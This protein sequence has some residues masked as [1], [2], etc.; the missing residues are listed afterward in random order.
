MVKIWGLA[1]SWVPFQGLGMITS[2]PTTTRQE[3][4]QLF[5]REGERPRQGE[6]CLFPRIS[7]QEVSGVA[8]I[9]PLAA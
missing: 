3:Q 5:L 4:D 9:C 1:G 7:D 8:G 6:G 2:S